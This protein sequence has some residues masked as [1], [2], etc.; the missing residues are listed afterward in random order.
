MGAD[1]EVYG[2]TDSLSLF[3]RSTFR[4]MLSA[5][6]LTIADEGLIANEVSMYN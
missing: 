3:F 5:T 4:M 1:R 2:R 6:I